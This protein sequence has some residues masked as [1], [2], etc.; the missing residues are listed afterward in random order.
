MIFFTEGPGIQTYADLRQT[1]VPYKKKKEHIVQPDHIQIIQ[2]TI[3]LS[4]I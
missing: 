2:E 3:N 4:V 1:M